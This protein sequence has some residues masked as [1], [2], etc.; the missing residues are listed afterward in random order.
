MLSTL[1]AQSGKATFDTILTWID[2]PIFFFRF[3]KPANDVSTNATVRIAFGQQLATAVNVFVFAYY[4]SV[5]QMSYDQSGMVS[6]VEY[7]YAS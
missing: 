6:G 3:P 4:G 5:V 1:A 2:A 7:S